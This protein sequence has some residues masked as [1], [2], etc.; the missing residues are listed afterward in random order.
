MDMP[1]KSKPLPVITAAQYLCKK[2]KWTLTP[3]Q[4]QK[5][6]YLAN[7]YHL[8]YHDEPIVDQK[9]EAWIYGPVQP[10]LY[11]TLKE[12][13]SGPVK[14]LPDIAGGSISASQKGVL[15]F[16]WETYGE[17]D[18]HQLIQIT[19]RD[20]GGWAKN[21]QPAYS[22]YGAVI[23]DEDIKEEFEVLTGHSLDAR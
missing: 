13:G 1:V 11:Q 15:D 6:L 14:W 10:S 17:L 23:P 19:H 18:A 8:A 12:F 4:V 5:L 16:V 3:L 22:R 7:M 9:F 2:S 21:W 20:G